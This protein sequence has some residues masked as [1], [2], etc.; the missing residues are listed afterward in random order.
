MYVTPETPTPRTATASSHLSRRS[1]VGL[2]AFST[3]AAALLPQ[4]HSPSRADAAPG[5]DVAPANGTPANPAPAPGE[6]IPFAAFMTDVHIDAIPAAQEEHLRLVLES[7]HEAGSPL[8]LHGGD[9]TEFGSA[10]EYDTYQEILGPELGEITEHVAGNHELRWDAAA[11]QLYR[12][13][14]HDS[15][16]SFEH[17]GVH[18]I[19][20]EV[21]VPMQEEAHVDPATVEWLRQDLEAAGEMPSIL[22]MHWPPG[23]DYHYVRAVDELLAVIGEHPVRLILAGHVHQEVTTVLNGTVLMTGRATKNEPVHYLLSLR[24][25]EEAEDSQAARELVIESVTQAVPGTEPDDAEGEGPTVE[26]VTAVPL[27][28]ATA[29]E[30]AQRPR[31]LS[32]RVAGDVARV[33]ARL[34][35]A[36]ALDSARAGRR[37]QAI[38]G[39]TAEGTW[40]ELSVRGRSITGTVDLASALPGHHEMRLRGIDA[41][42]ALWESAEPFSI[43]GGSVAERDLLQLEGPVNGALVPVA[44][45]AVLAATG[46]GEVTRLSATGSGLAADWSVGIGPVHRG[47]AL[48]AE[49]SVVHV[50]SAD[51]KLYALSVADGSEQWAVDLGHPVVSTPLVAAVGAQESIFVSA[52]DRLVRI[53]SDGQIVWS[54]AIPQ[55]SSGTPVLVGDQL[56]IGAGDGT[57]RAYSARTGRERWSAELT[58]RD[59]PYQRLLYGPWNTTGLALDARTVVLGTVSELVALDARTGAER[60]RTPAGAMYSAPQLLADGRILAVQERVEPLLIDPAGGEATPFDRALQISLD[61]DP[62]PIPGTNRFWQVSFSGVLSLLDPESLSVSSL[63]QVSTERIHATPA[64]LPDSSVLLVGDQAGAVRALDVS[65]L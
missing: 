32:V 26:E 48:S 58:D 24:G 54:V 25:R 10:S 34:G 63:R 33:S 28:S 62:V 31:D 11:G 44:A 53:S 3:G 1:L 43:P 64:L 65:G 59:T 23:V 17:L 19:M 29:G 55:Q 50:P 47:M 46:D 60:W 21:G 8:L 22:V 18:V 52:G 12:Q 20:L 36:G 42:G 6:T 2:A 40:T 45:E 9:I 4:V 7:V 35:R 37:D 51:Q 16:R 57:A 61:A 39:T 15:S 14:L 13:R 27:H 49:G 41:D 38:Y 56:V 5:A 30:A